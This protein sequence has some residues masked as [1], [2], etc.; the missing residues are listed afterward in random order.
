MYIRKMVIPYDILYWKELY[1]NEVNNNNCVCFAKRIIG[2]TR[3][4]IERKQ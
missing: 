1:N 3:V 2:Y 4:K